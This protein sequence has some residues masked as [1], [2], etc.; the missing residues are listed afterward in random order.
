MALQKA[1]SVDALNRSR[2]VPFGTRL[3]GLG[4]GVADGGDTSTNTAPPRAK[5]PSWYRDLHHSLLSMDSQ[6]DDD[7]DQ[8]NGN[9]EEEFENTLVKSRRI[10]SVDVDLNIACDSPRQY[11]RHV[12]TG[13]SED[14]LGCETLFSDYR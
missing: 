9:D 11:P 3:F 5:K 7:S 1:N 12:V 2:S 6:S 8:G 14:Q 13:K 10:A 4:G